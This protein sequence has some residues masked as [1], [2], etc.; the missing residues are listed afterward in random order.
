MDGVGSTTRLTFTTCDEGT[1]LSD[2]NVSVPEYVPVVRPERA[3]P[4][5]TV[6]APTP[7]VVES[8]IHGALGV[9][10]Q[11]PSVPPPEFRMFSVCKVGL[12]DPTT[13]LKSK[14]IGVR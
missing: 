9:I 7:E 1:A 13:A 10:V 6:C 11:L 12:L 2:E 8:V 4:T 14:F 5:L 3:A